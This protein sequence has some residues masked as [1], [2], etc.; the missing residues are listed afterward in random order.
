M[1]HAAGVL[2]LLVFIGVLAARAITH[3]AGSLRWARHFFRG[4]LVVSL[5]W[6][7][8]ILAVSWGNIV[9][10]VPAPAAECGRPGEMACVTKDDALVAN[11][12]PRAL[13]PAPLSVE[14]RR[15][16]HVAVVAL[17]PPLMLFGFGLA[18]AWVLRGFRGG[19]AA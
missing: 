16:E 9:A 19:A 5:L 13:R 12:T 15:A 6:V 11:L 14:L 2:L 8:M 10:P 7:A 18:C 3:R 4:W 1:L 17:L